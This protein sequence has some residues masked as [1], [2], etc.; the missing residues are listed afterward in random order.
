MSKPLTATEIEEDNKKFAEEM[1][2]I[3]KQI[4]EQMK[5]NIVKDLHYG[6]IIFNDPIKPE[7]TE[8]QLCTCSSK[9]LFNFGCRCGGK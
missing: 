2:R 1:S 7:S 8:E 3:V 6:D 5:Y 9:D 4:Q